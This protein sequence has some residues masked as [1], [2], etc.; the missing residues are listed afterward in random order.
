MKTNLFMHVWYSIF[1]VNA[2]GERFGADWHNW[3]QIHLK[4][5]WKRYEEIKYVKSSMPWIL[6]SFL[7]LIISLHIQDD[8]PNAKELKAAPKD[9]GQTWKKFFEN[10]ILK[11]WLEV[12]SS[13]KNYT[14]SFLEGPWSDSDHR[15]PSELHELVYQAWTASRKIDHRVSWFT[16]TLHFLFID[17]YSLWCPDANPTIW[18]CFYAPYVKSPLAFFRVQE[19]WNWGF[20]NQAKLIHETMTI[21]TS[22]SQ[23]TRT[24]HREQFMW[25]PGLV[26]IFSYAIF[27]NGVKT[28][29]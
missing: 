28:V 22:M 7:D 12:Y 17:L 8:N 4:K 14:I 1:R 10:S 9:P 20:W 21:Q 5:I 3:E 13:P 27:C 29:A 25:P 11:T 26:A 2:N 19:A 6:F 18:L 24:S 15:H 16:H 23:R